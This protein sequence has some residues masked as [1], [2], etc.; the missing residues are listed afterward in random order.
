MDGIEVIDNG[1]T[2][3]LKAIREHCK[4]CVG[5][6]REII[7]CGGEKSCKLYNFRFG[8][9]PFRK[10]RIMSDEQKEKLAEG[11]RKYN[12]EQK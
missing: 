9:N 5:G 4:D 3:P 12:E 6:Y 2:S 11:L 7:I 8:R 10:K 1:I